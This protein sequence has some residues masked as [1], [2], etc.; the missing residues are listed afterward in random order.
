MSEAKFSKGP[1]AVTQGSTGSFD[2]VFNVDGL[3]NPCKN[4]D[5][6][7]FTPVSC[8]YD[9]EDLFK[10]DTA[11]ANAHLIAAAPDLYEEIEREAAAIRFELEFNK[12]SITTRKSAALKSALSRKEKLLAKARGEYE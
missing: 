10:G 1:W 9:G 8:S 7:R 4:D 2:V 3:P 11:K 6:L 5:Y 12:I